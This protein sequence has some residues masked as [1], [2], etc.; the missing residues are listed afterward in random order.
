MSSTVRGD[1]HRPGSFP[2]RAEL[3]GTFGAVASDHWLASAAGMPVLER[4]GNAADAAT[5]AG[6]VLQVV[7]PDEHG[8]GG[9]MVALAYRAEADRVLVVCGQGPAPAAATIEAFDRLGL[10]M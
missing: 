4:A 1:E 5:A 7:E 2:S 9:D 8:P 10:D 6:F 3:T